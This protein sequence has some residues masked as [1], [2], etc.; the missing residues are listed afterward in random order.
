MRPLYPSAQLL[1]CRLTTGLSALQRH[2]RELI[3]SLFKRYRPERHYT[4]GP[5][6]KWRE[7]HTRARIGAI[8]RQIGRLGQFALLR[9]QRRPV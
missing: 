3:A 2:W 5:G 9:R 4:R 6:P 7:R 1:S 8:G